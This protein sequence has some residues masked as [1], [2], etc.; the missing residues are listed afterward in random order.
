[1]LLSM[2]LFL[3]FSLTLGSFF[4]WLAITAYNRESRRHAG[5]TLSKRVYIDAS[6]RDRTPTQSHR[7]DN[8]HMSSGTRSI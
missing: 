3:I 2:L 7:P 5:P 6:L 1:M 8:Q 4:L